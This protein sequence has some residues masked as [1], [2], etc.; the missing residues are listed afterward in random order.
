VV[1]V[2][3]AVEAVL[4]VAVVVVE[5]VTLVVV[6]AVVEVLVIV[7]EV[8]TLML[9]IY[10]SLPVSSAVA[11]LNPCFICSYTAFLV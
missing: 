6:V 11:S 2:V 7:G 8:S 3:I 5:A 1:V 4:V 9:R 10:G